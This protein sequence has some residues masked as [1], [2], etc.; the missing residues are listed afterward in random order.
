MGPYGPIGGEWASKEKNYL[1]T[2]KILSSGKRPSQ[3]VC[4]KTLKLGLYNLSPLFCG[5]IL[6][7]FGSV[8][9]HAWFLWAGALVCMRYSV[10]VSFLLVVGSV[11]GAFYCC[12]AYLFPKA[13]FGKECA[14][15]LLSLLARVGFFSK[16][17]S[18][19]FRSALIYEK[20]QESRKI[21]QNRAEQFLF[22]KRSDRRNTFFT[23]RE[24]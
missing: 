11:F 4:L 21:P 1:S 19:T 15:F 22:L 23:Y 12:Y 8:A 3:K 24:I 7:L 9:S 13:Y 5:W 20:E 17:V 18:D 2:R 14:V 16:T 10:G 6:D